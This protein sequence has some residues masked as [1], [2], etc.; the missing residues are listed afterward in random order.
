MNV[1]QTMLTSMVVGLLLAGSVSAQTSSIGA[2]QRKQDSERTPAENAAEAAT[3]S[4]GPDVA[5]THPAYDKFSWITA[6]PAPAPSFKVND[7]VTVIVR[8]TAKYEADADLK[9]DSK[10]DVKSELEAFVKPFEG[11]LGA[12]VFRRGKPNIEYNYQTKSD[13]KADTSREDKYTTR[14]TAKIIDVK[15][16]G[17]LVLEARG[18]FKHDE[19]IVRVTLTGTCRKEDV[20]AD[21]SVLSTQLADKQIEVTTEGAVRDGTRRGWIRRLVD[22]VKPV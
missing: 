20:T 9:S 13:N 1:S 2:Q 21:N 4:A 10:Y 22:A 7:L 15:P 5:K 14:I 8:E 12:A 19:E 18:K 17:L 6:R 16:N 11:G 3:Q